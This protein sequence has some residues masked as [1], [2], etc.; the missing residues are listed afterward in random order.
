MLARESRALRSVVAD[1]AQLR[2]ED[3]QAILADLD[4]P[5][6]DRLA[7][8]LEAY[9]NGDASNGSPVPALAAIGVGPWLSDRLSAGRQGHPGGMTPYAI[10][11]LQRIAADQGWSASPVEMRP[12]APQRLIDRM[13]WRS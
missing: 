4:L 7:G 1:L 5:S 11:A 2:D 12:P 13:G 10:Q 6:R 8:L 9:K 3:V